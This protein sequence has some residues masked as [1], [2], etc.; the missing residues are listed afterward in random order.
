V[1]NPQN[2]EGI[3]SQHQSKL[4]QHLGII[5]ELCNE[6]KLAEKIDELMPKNYR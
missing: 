5:A 4:I 6:V 3:M 2:Q 1:H